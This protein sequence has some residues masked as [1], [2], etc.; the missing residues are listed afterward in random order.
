FV[1]LGSRNHKLKARAGQKRLAVT[2]GI[3]AGALAGRLIAARAAI[4]AP[5]SPVL[6]VSIEIEVRRVRR[7]G[8]RPGRGQ[9]NAQAGSDVVLPFDISNSG[10]AVEQVDA[11]LTLPDGWSSRDNKQGSMS[12]SPGETV[13]RRIRLKVPPLSATGSSFVGINLLSG[14]DTL[15]T[16]TM[17]IEVFNSGSIG[18][19]AGPLITTAYSHALDENGVA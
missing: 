18:S 2:I 10:N 3:P 6:I 16:E 13:K 17:T 5:R 1:I 7:V 12:I 8:L 9:L 15:A 19:Q 11:Q 14:A 4:V